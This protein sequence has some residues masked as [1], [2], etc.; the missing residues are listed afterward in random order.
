VIFLGNY[1][2]IFDN[3]YDVIE[4]LIKIKQ[5]YN[6]DKVIFLRGKHDELMLRALHGSEVDFNLWM[7][8]GGRTTI[9]GYLKNINSKASP[10]DIG[11]NRISDIVPN[12]HIQFLQETDHYYIIEDQYCVFN[13]GFNVKQSIKDN[14]INNFCFDTTSSK[15]IKDCIRNKIEP[16]FMDSYIFIGSNNYQ[17]KEPF[18][19][20]KYMMLGG[21]D[22]IIILELNSMEMSAITNGKSRIYKYD[23]DVIE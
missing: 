12:N 9:A 20:Y 23:Y 7:D 17:G 5:E 3:G 13:S 2:D 1:I 21:T 15:Y 4:L 8:A 18:I 6:N 10:Y 16:S 11:V 19:Y 14:N 22:K